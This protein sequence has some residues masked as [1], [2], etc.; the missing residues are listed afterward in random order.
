MKVLRG[1]LYSEVHV[2]G[3]KKKKASVVPRDAV[4]ARSNLL[5]VKW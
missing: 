1:V 4:S 2:N 3:F 5:K